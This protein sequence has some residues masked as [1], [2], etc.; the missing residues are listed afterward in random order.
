M[1]TFFG[2]K[3]ER[4]REREREKYHNRWMFNSPSPP[5]S[6]TR[7]VKY[8]KKQRSEKFLLFRLWKT[9]EDCGNL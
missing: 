3:R 9:V 5:S 4:E 6:Q 1:K 2:K 7:T 8:R